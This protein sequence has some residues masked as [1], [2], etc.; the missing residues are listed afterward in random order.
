MMNRVK[1][2]NDHM[3]RE[4]MEAVRRL[5]DISELAAFY[6]PGE[7][8][9]FPDKVHVDIEFARDVLTRTSVELDGDEIARAANKD[10]PEPDE[11][12][13]WTRTPWGGLHYHAYD[14]VTED[15]DGPVPWG[16]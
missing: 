15:D 9:E 11:H 12:G 5:L 16:E 13:Y 1:P 8:G 3:K 10:V 6:M 7:L 14:P 4:L 2:T